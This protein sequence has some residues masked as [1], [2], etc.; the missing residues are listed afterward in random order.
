MSENGDQ[1]SFDVRFHLHPDV[2]VAQSKSG[3]I[4]YLG[5]AGG[6]IWQF[7]YRGAALA[8]EDSIYFGEAGKVSASKQI[9]LS[10]KTNGAI[11]TILWSLR[12]E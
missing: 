8:L 11:T 5:L 4:L 12:L 3:N 9:V 6:E 1:V 2:S 7:R 10:G